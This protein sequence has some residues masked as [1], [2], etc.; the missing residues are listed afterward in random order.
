MKGEPKMRYLLAALLT[1]GFATHA[2]GQN[3]TC[4]VQSPF[5]VNHLD[6]FYLRAL[7]C[8]QAFVDDAWSRF[9]MAEADGDRAWSWFGS[10]DMCNMN[11]P[12]GRTINALHLMELA[13]TQTPHCDSGQIQVLDWAYC[14]AGSEIGYLKP[15]CDVQGHFSA[16]TFTGFQPNRTELY[17]A[18]F[19]EEDVWSRAAAIFHEARHAEATCGHTDN[20]KA[21]PASCDA[22]WESGCAGSGTGAYAF[23]VLWLSRFATNAQPHLINEEI[24][25][26]VIATAVSFL[27]MNFAQHPCFTI[28]I[29]DGSFDGTGCN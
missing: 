25:K 15:V 23:T 29:T 16:K 28:S 4:G 12:F 21:G 24:R 18:F 10:Q 17:T 13:S 6:D 19:Y 22:N 14:Y 11:L 8:D 1:I 3:S 26:K 20:C 2:H 9:H 27:D 7:G 5:N